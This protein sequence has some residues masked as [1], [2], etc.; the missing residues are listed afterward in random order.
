MET[1]PVDGS[2]GRGEYAVYNKGGVIGGD[3]NYNNFGNYSK[4]QQSN[5]GSMKRCS[6]GGRS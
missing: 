2:G 3:R 6:I 5:Y 1:K 4:Q